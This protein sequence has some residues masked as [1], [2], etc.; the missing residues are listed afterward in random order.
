MNINIDTDLKNILNFDDGFDYDQAIFRVVPINR[1]LSLLHEGVNVL[2]HPSKWEDPFENF[3]LKSKFNYNGQPLGV[4]LLANKIYGQCW[5]LNDVETDALWRIYS[6]QKTGVRI[7][8]TM[9][10]LLSP[11][12]QD[13]VVDH[14]H[15]VYLGKVKYVKEA[16]LEAEMKNLKIDAV[17]FNI[18][19]NILTIQSMLVK[20]EVFEHENEVRIIYRSDENLTKGLYRYRI[21]PQKFILELLFDPR[22]EKNLYDVFEHHL[23]VILPGCPI[24]QSTLYRSPDF[25]VNITG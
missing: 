24:S 22:M 14:G 15:K 25:N 3:F 1:L 20:R 16:D 10:S 2:V 9:R 17:D 8:S 11:L 21:V 23:K 18:K 4:D 12:I 6:P 5:T 7:K 19:N 13:N